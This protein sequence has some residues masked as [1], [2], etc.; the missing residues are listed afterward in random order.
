MFGLPIRE[1]FSTHLAMHR[2]LTRVE[3]LDVKPQVSFPP[4]SCGAKLALISG[5]IPRV[6]SSVGLQ[7]VTLSEPGM[8]NVTF[9]R[10]FT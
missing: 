2:L 4:A 10:L 1:A 5:F 9:V 6:D 3:L 7:A 8:T